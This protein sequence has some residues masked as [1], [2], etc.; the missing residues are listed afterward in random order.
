M[1][2]AVLFLVAGSTIIL[3]GLSAP[4]LSDIRAVSDFT[5]SRQSFALAEG[6]VEDVTYRVLSGLPVSTTENL[7]EGT[8]AVETVQ[9]SVLGELEIT[10]TGDE[11][12]AIRTA[13]IVLSE[14]S[15]ASFNYG[16]Q[17]GEGGVH[18]KN[19]ASI[20]GNVFS[21][22]PVT[23]ENSN[24]VRGE[25]IS[26]GPSGLVDGV[27][28]TSSVY[29][30]TIDDSDIDGDA[31]YQVISDSTVDGTSY[32]GSADQ[33]TSS[34]P[35]SDAQIEEWKAIAVAGGTYGG[36]C[37]YTITVNTAIGPIKIPCDLEITGTPTVTLA[38]NVWVEG[39][40]EVENSA[41]INVSSS[42]SGK[43]VAVIADKPSSPTSS[44]TIALKNST[45]FNGYG[46]DSYILFISQNTSAESGGSTAA[47]T[48]E[49]S[50]SGDVLVYASHGKIDLKNS[51]Q[52]KEVTAYRIEVQNSGEVVYES[53]LVNLLFTSGPAGGYSISSWNEI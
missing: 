6:G 39:S 17:S 49:N 14:G 42:L 30:H 18:L 8:V 34:L 40:I 10:G 7:T 12:N 25:I 26:A 38:G 48:V 28:A 29:A 21:N 51:V 27:H 32:P 50:A 35:I 13:Q 23:G 33:A 5:A 19:T 45:T 20:R 2:M 16:L 24:I 44:G 47:I 1:L 11:R 3:S 52:I 43:T 9:E 31:H 53:G 36:S 15:G 41:I 22:G 37:P 4:V 46:D